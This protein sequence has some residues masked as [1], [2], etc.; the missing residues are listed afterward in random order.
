[1]A[2]CTECGT[3]MHKEDSINHVCNTEDIPEKN[4]PIRKG[5]KKTEV[6]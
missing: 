6:A 2:F 1:M 3:V 5:F 4:K